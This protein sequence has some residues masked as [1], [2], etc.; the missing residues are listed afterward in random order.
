MTK[1]LKILA[2][3]LVG[4][5]AL[6]VLWLGAEIFVFGQSV[7]ETTV[8]IERGMDVFDIAELLKNRGL[9]ENRFGFVLYVTLT[10]NINNLQ[11]GEYVFEGDY[12]LYQVADIVSNGLSLSAH[13][14]VLI[15]EGFTL[16][17]IDQK[18]LGEGVN[19]VG[20]VSDQKVSDFEEDFYFLESVRP[21]TDS[22]EGF[23][24]PDTYRFE[25]HSPAGLIAR[26][27]LAN[28]EKKTRSWREKAAREGRDFY[29]VLV[30]ASIL[31]KEV[32]PEDMTRAAGVLAK[33]L[34]AGI[35][36]GADATLVYDLGRPIKRSDLEELD[37]PYNSYKYPGL[38][39]TPISNPSLDALE[40]A[41]NPEKND[42]WYYLS[43]RDNGETI[44]SQTLE[45]HNAARAK[46]LR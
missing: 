44:F 21:P 20:R 6:V 17:E 11:A 45:E 31:E 46:Y 22:L 9:I 33:R 37:S 41:L 3:V 26:V 7:G 24:F 39:P 36:L 42:Y 43:R 1:L 23:L 2:A 32:P 10:G 38:P 4:A 35:A 5:A 8:R 40:A 28:F 15:P 19:P 34:A 12:S 14:T 18:L 27:M 29:E 25:K 30:L 13:K 16:E